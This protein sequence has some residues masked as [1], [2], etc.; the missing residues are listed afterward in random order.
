MIINALI[1]LIACA[2]VVHGK[3]TLKL[4]LAKGESRELKPVD[5]Q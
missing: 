2:A 3:G 5:F 4:S 1:S